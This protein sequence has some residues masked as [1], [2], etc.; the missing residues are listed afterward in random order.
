M[1]KRCIKAFRLGHFFN[2]YNQY[3]HEKICHFD[4]KNVIDILKER[5]FSNTKIIIKK[6]NLSEKDL[7]RIQQQNKL[8]YNDPHLL[9]I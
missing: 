9:F 8:M 6:T 4:K 3:E 2:N 5:Y 7:F 1:W